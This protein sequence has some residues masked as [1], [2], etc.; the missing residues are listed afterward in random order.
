VGMPKWT[1]EDQAFAKEV[2]DANKFTLKPL[3][4]EVPKISTPESR[5]VST[6]GGSDDIGDIMW[7]VPTITMRYPSN[8]PNTTGHHV[9]AAIAMTTP[10]A[11]KGAVAGAKALALTILD[12]ATTPSL[13]TQA[14]AY[15][16]D[17]QTKDTKYAP[18]LVASDKPAIHLNKDLMTLIR[19]QMEKFYYDPS[20][21][22]TY[23]E[24]L[25]IKYPPAPAAK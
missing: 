10:I 23:L 12:I 14:K 17:V 19:P 7:T 16:T 15:F 21:H 22:Q 9:T 5:G 2:Q 3:A 18:V 11:H 1:A 24:Q 6:G 13:V 25:G 4:A 20:K 8:V